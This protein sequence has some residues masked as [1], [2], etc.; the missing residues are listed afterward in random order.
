MHDELAILT[1]G[2]GGAAL[3]RKSPSTCME[4]RTHFSDRRDHSEINLRDLPRNNFLSRSFD[5]ERGWQK[6][7][8]EV[9][10]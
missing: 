1:G 10:T 9:Q 5:A 7:A 6:F 2:R 8:V 3:L 4:M